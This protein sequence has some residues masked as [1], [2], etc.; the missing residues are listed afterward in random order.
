VYIINRL[1]TAVLS[2]L[3]PF[4]KLFNTTPDYTLMRVFGCKCFPLLRPYTANKLEY[5]SK[6]CIF[7]GYS[8][9]GYR[10]LD[11]VT[12]CVYLSHHVIFDES[13]FPA[14]DAAN[15]SL[16]S[17]ITA[18]ED[19]PF[20]MPLHLSL[21]TSGNSP[22]P[23]Y[24]SIPTSPTATVPLPTGPQPS[25]VSDFLAI[26]VVSASPQ[27]E[28]FPSAAPLPSPVIASKPATNSEP[29]N[30]PIA[31]PLSH[32]MLTRSRTGASPQQ[33]PSL[34][35]APLPSPA[36]ASEPATNSEPPNLPIAAPLSH[37][38]LTR[39]RTGASQPKQ[40]PDFHLYYASKH[41]PTTL[42][43]PLALQEPSLLHKG[44]Y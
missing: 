17:R 38:M 41:P 31:A 29:L 40:F 8:H 2:Q 39:S 24:P 22:S 12:G 34:F 15:S 44:S 32:P 10:C 21:S 7:L 36:T 1:P 16:P 18:L 13:S 11:P 9:A 6:P 4:E 14:K 27:Q 43:S 19:A 42:P 28:P 30:L 3:S 23:T 25:L 37:P 20:F 35:A 33:E 5:R 26:D